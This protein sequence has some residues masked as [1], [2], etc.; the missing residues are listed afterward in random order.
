MGNNTSTSCGHG[1]VENDND[2]CVGT[3][4]CGYGT[5]KKGN[6]CV[7]TL[8]PIIEPSVSEF[9]KVCGDGALGFT[10]GSKQETQCENGMTEIVTKCMFTPNMDDTA[11]LGKCTTD[12]MKS[13]PF[14]S[15]A[16]AK[17]GIDLDNH[18]PLTGPSQS[19]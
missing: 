1:T 11:K 2:T 7:A 8:P 17:A 16:S 13:D 3:L 5:V 12:A 18:P 15:K 9:N 19:S 6:S 4:T 10:K 14:F